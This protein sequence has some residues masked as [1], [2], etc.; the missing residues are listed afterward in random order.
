VKP[1]DRSE[2]GPIANPLFFLS[3][4]E[5]YNSIHLKIDEII[6]NSFTAAQAYAKNFTEFRSVFLF[7]KEWD[8]NKY[9]ESDP[10]L[11]KFAADL[12]K[13]KQWSA[14][15]DRQIILLK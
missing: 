15:M 6:T 2:E 1:P 11:D 3:N 10:T 14:D 13:F 9:K 12:L 4:V 8:I 7:G 5:S